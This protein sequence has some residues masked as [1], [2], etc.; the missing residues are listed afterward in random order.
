MKMIS[1]KCRWRD[2]EKEREGKTER[3]GGR[4]GSGKIKEEERGK[5]VFF[6]TIK[7][8]VF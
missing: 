3:E 7:N 2:R 8:Y 4:K 1:S 5:I 6:K